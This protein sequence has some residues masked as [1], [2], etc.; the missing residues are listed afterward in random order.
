[1][2]IPDQTGKTAIALSQMGP[3]EH[4]FKKYYPF[5]CTIVYK[6]VGDKSKVEDIAQEIFTELWLK[7]DHIFIHSSVPAYLRRM[8]ISRTLN[9][10]R[11]SKK[12]NWDDL[13]SNVETMPTV[14]YQEPE[15]LLH[16]DEEELKK[17]LAVAIDKLPEKC[18]IVFLM[19][20]YDELSYA[21]IAENLDISIKT[22]ENQIGKALKYLRLA[23]NENRG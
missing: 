19:S 6:Y 22:V 2:T 15:A 21:E 13:D 14:G 18:R 1:M 17:K 9:Y 11:D 4:L 3:F 10:L 12:Y 7:R 20:R 16:L 5:V 23:I 8:A